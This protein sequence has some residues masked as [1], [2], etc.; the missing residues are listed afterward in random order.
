MREPRWAFLLLMGGCGGDADGDGFSGGKDCDDDD[1]SV[2]VGAVELCNGVDDDCDGGEDP[3]DQATVAGARYDTIQQAIDAAGE[4]ATVGVCAGNYVENLVIDRAITLLSAAGADATVIDG[5][6][7]ETSTIFASMG[8]D[9]RFELGGMTI[10]GGSGSDNPN[11][12][13]EVAGGG[14]HVL[15]AGDVAIHDCVFFGNDADWGAGMYTL[16]VGGTDLTDLTF[17]ANNAT[18]GGGGLYVAGTTTLTRVSATENRAVGGAG[19]FIDGTATLADCDFSD[20][21][22]TDLAGGI[23]AELAQIDLGNTTITG[24]EAKNGGGMLLHNGGSLT[25]GTITGN[26]GEWAVAS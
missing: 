1:P 25:G 4:G 3:T 13:G 24:N 17:E 2:H 16:G 20:N 21:E 18:L 15:I 7:D 12:E 11:F 6:G 26:T 9:E 8:G 5:S 19:A 22:A 23:Y 10:T 14:V